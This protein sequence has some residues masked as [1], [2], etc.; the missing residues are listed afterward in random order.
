VATDGGRARITF[1]TF[2]GGP[3]TQAS[4]ISTA[5]G[6]ATILSG[7]R[8][9]IKFDVKAADVSAEGINAA[10]GLIVNDTTGPRVDSVLGHSVL[11][12][13]LSD[14]AFGAGSFTVDFVAPFDV[15]YLCVGASLSIL[16]GD[17]TPGSSWVEFDNVTVVKLPDPPVSG[18]PL[19]GISLTNFFKEIILRSE[20][21][22]LTDADVDYTS[23][24]AI[25][26]S[27][28]YPFGVYVQ[29]AIT[30]DGLSRAPLDSFCASITE[31]ETGAR[32][33]IR[34]TD[35]ELAADGDIVAEFDGSNLDDM[36]TWDRDPAIGLTARAG[37]PHNWYQFTDGTQFVDDFDPATGIDAQTRAQFMRASQNFVSTDVVLD[38]SYQFALDADPIPYL[39]DLLADAKA[40]LNRV[41]GM[42]TKV[43]KHYTFSGALDDQ[44]IPRVGDIVRVTWP[45]GDLAAGKKLFVKRV[46][47]FPWSRRADITAWG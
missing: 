19:Q 30:I 15:R 3:Q 2:T 25:D 5:I 24:D 29:S 10:F 11:V 12:G 22:G 45:R 38:P 20:R 35:P 26:T 46:R 14:P 21:A 40:E 44:S 39:L 6:A 1:D 41:C 36:P 28:P 27:A 4:Y 34:L 31:D 43:R 42:F 16:S 18:A 8:Y 13:S 7:K 17:P 47:Y 32:R 37:A 33:V 23:T 9:R